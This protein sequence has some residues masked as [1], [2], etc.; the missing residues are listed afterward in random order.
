MRPEATED[1]RP[2]PSAG[3]GTA[4]TERSRAFRHRIPQGIELE[5]PSN[6]PLVSLVF[7]RGQ[8]L[9]RPH[10]SCRVRV[11]DLSEPQFGILEMLLQ[12]IGTLLPFSPMPQFPHLP[13]ATHP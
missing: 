7:L 5:R 8:L 6:S 12:Y 11:H 10:H 13:H 9:G 3:D 1:K 4:G 2:L